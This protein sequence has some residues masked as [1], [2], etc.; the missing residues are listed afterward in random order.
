MEN[1]NQVINGICW[2]MWLTLENLLREKLSNESILLVWANRTF[3]C[4]WKG[5]HEAVSIRRKSDVRAHCGANMQSE[6]EML[7]WNLDLA[8][9][10]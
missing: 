3:A 1:V 6:S 10:Q 8:R 7:P 5:L 9:L 4:F 2:P